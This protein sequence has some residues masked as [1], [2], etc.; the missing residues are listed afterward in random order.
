MYYTYTNRQFTVDNEE[1]FSDHNKD[2][3]WYRSSKYRK[4]PKPR[5]SKW[6]T[7]TLNVFMMLLQYYTL[8]VGHFKYI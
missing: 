8:I 1:C 3:C 7:K 6:M 2:G 5:T 4:I